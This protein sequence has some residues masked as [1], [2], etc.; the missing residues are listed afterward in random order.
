MEFAMTEWRTS[1]ATTET[2]AVAT[3]WIVYRKD[4]VMSL[5]ST[6]TAPII[7]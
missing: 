4:C 3:T 6:C 1:D 2:I 5:D 7:P